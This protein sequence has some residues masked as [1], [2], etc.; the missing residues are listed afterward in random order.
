MQRFI[1]CGKDRTRLLS[2]IADGNNVG[3]GLTHEFLDMFR[4]MVTHINAHFL[5]GDDRHGI[6]P[7]RTCPCADNLEAAPGHV[8][9]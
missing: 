2:S 4:K 3:K 1:Y 7:S 9:E 5:H 8:A 6:K